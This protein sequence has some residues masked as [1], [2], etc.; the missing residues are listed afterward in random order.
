MRIGRLEPLCRFK[1]SRP[2]VCE[3]GLNC[4]GL[5][6]QTRKTNASVQAALAEQPGL[7]D[8]YWGVGKSLYLQGQYEAALP[9][10]QHYVELS[11][12]S[13]EP[14]YLLFQFFRRMNNTKEAEKK[15]LALFK[16]KEENAKIKN[17]ARIAPPGD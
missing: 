17:P 10:L 7:I 5:S 9:Q 11:P 15:E 12:D 13:S 1:G 14:H 3:F 16:E 6:S 2:L 8:G 4:Y